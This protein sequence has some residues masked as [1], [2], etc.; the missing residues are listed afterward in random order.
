MT[1]KN[2]GRVRKK[3]NTKTPNKTKQK[4]I[5]ERSFD[6]KNF[7]MVIMILSVLIFIFILSSSTGLIG[8]ALASFF[9]SVFGKLSLVFPILLFASFYLV[10]REKFREN[11]SRMLLIYGIYLLT[12][13]FLSK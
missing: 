5:R 8:E 9:E 10:Y 12:L 1:N 7:S 6:L 2:S 3:T 4:K 11:L 13:A